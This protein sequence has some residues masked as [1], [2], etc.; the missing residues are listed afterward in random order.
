MKPRSLLAP[1]GL[2]LVGWLL[3]GQV[4][5]L[6]A[7]PSIWPPDDFVEYWAAGH[8]NLA[9]QDPYAPELLLPLQRAAGRDTDEA[10]MMWNPP[11]TLTVVMPLG[12]L[13]AR[14]AQLAWL[15]VGVAAVGASAHL[16][17]RA[18]GGSAR[19]AWLAWV[20]A[21]SFAPTL[22]VLQSGQIG[23]L[24]LFGAA[25]FVWLTRRGYG[26][27]AGAVAV[28]LAI[29]PHLVYL[30]W[31]A[32]VVDALANRRW[33]VLLGGAAM[34]LL[35]SALPMLFNPEVFAQYFAAM[36]DH[37]PAQ[38]VSLTLGTLL[39]LAFG[40]QRFG[41]QFVPVLIGLGWFAWHW[42]RHGRNWDWGEQLP[43]LVLVSFLTS[44][45]GAW[46]FDLVL[47]LLSILHRAAQ[48][49][50]REFTPQLGGVIGVYCLAELAMIGLNV[51]EWPS[52]W[53]AWVA[54]LV[55]AL[56]VVT[57]PRPAMAPQ[58]VVALA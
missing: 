9:G 19:R 36:R 44:P 5:Q 11:W 6:L 14:V 42:R 38:W 35:T 55:A 39:R 57:A 29:K 31:V 26:A 45:Y 27:W 58:P 50:A 40:E 4:R 34:G 28:L 46:H 56:Y 30:L 18:Y 54:P 8:L 15:L 37:P 10:V 7:D 3:V 25:L 2:L 43:T 12:A 41:L 23:P 53:F 22:L 16:L 48:L 24:L 47:L 1:V 52:F 49:S 33:A 13:P 21:L 20:L 32:V 17:W 51:A